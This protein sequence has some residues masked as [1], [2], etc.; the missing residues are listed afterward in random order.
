LALQD[1]RGFESIAPLILNVIIAAT[2]VHE[3]IGPILT[4][5]ILIK[6]GECE[7]D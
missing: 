7:E 4:K 6:S 1:E 3:F 2:I 5:Y